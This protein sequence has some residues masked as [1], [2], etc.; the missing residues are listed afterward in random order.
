MTSPNDLIEI[1]SDENEDPVS[2]RHRD[3]HSG[4]DKTKASVFSFH[5]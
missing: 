3:R 5:F 1:D 2:S 4:R